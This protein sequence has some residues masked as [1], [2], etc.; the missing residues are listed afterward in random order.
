MTDEN[1]ATA[2]PEEFNLDQVVSEAYD[3]ATAEPDK[4]ST[5]EL[6]VVETTETKDQGS[7]ELAKPAE[8]QPLEPHSRWSTEDKDAFKALPREAQE[9]VL[10]R[11]SDVEKLLTQ[12]T[13]EIAEQRKTY[14]SLESV[15][16]PR[17]QSLM[18]EG[19]EVAVINNLLQIRDYMRTDPAG[20][21]KWL[22]EQNGVEPGSKPVGI[23]TQDP[24][25]LAQ[26]K[27]ID[28]LE[29]E[30]NQEKQQAEQARIGT[31]RKEITEFETEK[32]AGGNLKR[33][34][35]N[36]VRAEMA[37]LFKADLVNNLQDA[38]DRAVY[39][40]PVTRAKILEDVKK[41]DEKA[42]IESAKSA[43]SKAEKAVGVKVKTKTPAST[44]VTSGNWEDD[45][46]SIVN[47]VYGA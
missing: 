16:A 15:I 23:E 7:E 25:L 35:V 18:A 14:E 24:A 45:L 13:Q 47:A 1:I 41:S 30:R 9:I 33:P 34:Y 22:A 39:T 37:A 20:C 32:D 5:E 38:Y 4:E 31:V 21:I 43:A 44:G 29:Q 46:P 42:R 26:Q 3:K 27:R 6:P 11:E 2:E 12:K 19:G 36:D 10:K 40:N 8:K 17:R 28:A